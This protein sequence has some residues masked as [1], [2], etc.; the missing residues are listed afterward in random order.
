M[1]HV[2]EH[3]TRDWLQAS[4]PRYGRRLTDEERV[5]NGYICRFREMYNRGPRRNPALDDDDGALVPLAD[6]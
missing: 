1:S 6:L 4:R 3:V 5:W 2:S